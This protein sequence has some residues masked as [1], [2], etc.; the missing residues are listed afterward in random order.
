MTFNTPGVFIIEK[1][2]FPPSIV[3]VETA[4]PVFIGY[5][6]R[7]PSI[8]PD[9]V[10]TS[11]PQNPLDDEYIVP[12]EINSLE[13]YEAQFGTVN[14]SSD[15]SFNIVS[16]LDA[17]GNVGEI[18]SS[19]LDFTS[20]DDDIYKYNLYHALRLF[21]D[22]GG[23]RCFVIPVGIHQVNSTTGVKTF[24]ATP[25]QYTVALKA[26]ETEDDP[27]LIIFPELAL[28]VSK[29]SGDPTA[30]PPIEP[31][32]DGSTYESVYTQAMA[33]SLDRKDRFVVI[34]VPELNTG[35]VPQ[36]V[37]QDIGDF[38][39]TLSDFGFDALKFAAAYYPYLMTN[40]NAAN[41]ATND[42]EL[43]NVAVNLF[44][45]QERDPL[46][47]ISTA[48]P[49]FTGELHQ[50]GIVEKDSG[51]IS[52]P[53]SI[54][55]V[56]K[57]SGLYNSLVGDLS[58]L[59]F[60][61]PP[62]PVIAGIYARVDDQRGVFKAPANVTLASI[63]EPT[64]KIDDG[65]QGRMNVHTSGKAINAIR[66]ISNRGLV[67]WGARTL[68]ANNLDF[69]YVNVRRFFNFVEESVKQAM[70]RFVF[71]PNDA[72]TWVPIRAAIENFLTVQWEAGALQGAK[73][74]DAFFVQVGLG[75]TMS[76]IDIL[77]GKLR[78]RIGMAVV[79]PAEFIILEFSQ[80]LP[81]S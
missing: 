68:D 21:Y 50:L 23:G 30:S 80:I 52:D 17:D 70:Y 32:V 35:T 34:D 53:A 79:R 26:L 14:H 64:T 44:E 15:F 16:R 63:S 27:T 12:F 25:D 73:A 8:D 66:T 40:V 77:E 3:P 41:L 81:Q 20:A 58:Q 72:N 49:T 5:T 69:R 22:N 24:G 42:D 65:I 1:P 39:M 45:I 57:Y 38:R 67:V 19:N 76:P 28:T 55:R 56:D 47:D 60:K 62:S 10:T 6:E 59:P 74:D 46:P 71:E 37:S 29:T 43:I 11:N 4:I 54:V 33:Q 7:H 48:T 18:V 2:S 36:K 75:E 51:G 61:I 13:E 78:V 9:T 31:T